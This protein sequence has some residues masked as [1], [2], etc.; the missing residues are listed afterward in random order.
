K[1]VQSGGR[2]DDLFGQSVD[3]ADNRTS[4]FDDEDAEE[5]PPDQFYNNSLPW[6]LTIAYSVTYNNARR[7][8]EISSNSLMFSGNVTLSPGW[9]IGFSSGYDFKNKGVTYTQLRFERDLKSW[10]MN[11]TWIPNGYNK[12]W[13]F[14]IGISSTILQDIKYEK[15]N[16]PDRIYR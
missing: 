8:N 13:N 3:L 9:M 14:F 1:N 10:R 4:M 2:A 11:F 7:N 5:R 15:R 12:Q 16:S 6:N